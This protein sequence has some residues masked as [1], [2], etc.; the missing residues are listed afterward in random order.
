MVGLR[1]LFDSGFQHNVNKS[2]LFLPKEGW[3]TG[4]IHVLLNKLGGVFNI[5]SI[6]E[7]FIPYWKFEYIENVTLNCGKKWEV[8]GATKM[9]HLA[10]LFLMH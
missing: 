7:V 1:P 2:Y 10:F 4:Y 3:N 9:T 6:Q 8:Y 5:I